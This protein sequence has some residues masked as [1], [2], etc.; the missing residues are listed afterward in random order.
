M[1]R[2]IA[3][4]GHTCVV[5]VLNMKRFVE[6]E[7]AQKRFETIR[8]SELFREALQTAWPESLSSQSRFTPLHE[9]DMTVENVGFATGVFRSLMLNRLTAPTYS[10][11]KS[12]VH[13]RPDLENNFQF[14]T[15]FKRAW[16]RW[17]ISVRPLLD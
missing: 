12:Q 14:K 15:L 3:A 6:G 5:L 13:F 8:G 7:A 4:K 2:Q 16:D 1:S 11:D 17:E 9:N 10:L